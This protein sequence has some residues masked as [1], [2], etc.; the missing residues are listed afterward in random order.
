M[1]ETEKTE[2]VAT[3]QTNVTTTTQTTAEKTAAVASAVDETKIK[4]VVEN[5]INGL[6]F[7]GVIDKDKVV[8]DIKNKLTE[9]GVEFKGQLETI[10]KELVQKLAEDT[11]EAVT[12]KIN[13]ILDQKKAQWA[14]L[15]QEDPDEARRKLR[16]F[17]VG[18]TG[19]ASV[20][21]LVVG[22][23]LGVFVF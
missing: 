21:S 14:E 10:V 13:G 18:V 23:L 20:V 12:E 17:W 15:A 2:T 3:E 8:E 7:A 19:V 16:T 11:G 6:D 4:E 1:S 9:I 5:I 22:A